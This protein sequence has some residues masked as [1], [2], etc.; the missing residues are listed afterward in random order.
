MSFLVVVIR[1]CRLR[2]ALGKEA[3]WYKHKP[4]I[5]EEGGGMVGK[6]GR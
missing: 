4:C 2:L 5:R 6:G 1:L 3:T